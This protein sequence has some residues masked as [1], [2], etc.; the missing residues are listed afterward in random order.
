MPTCAATLVPPTAYT[1]F[2]QPL[3]AGIH[4]IVLLA[5]LVVIIATVY[6]AIKIEDLSLLPKQV[7]VMSTQILTFM[8]LA[9]A[10]LWLLSLL[11]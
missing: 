5:L 4:W 6:K 7:A 11:F 10:A 3:P 9:A 2:L 1:P 8:I